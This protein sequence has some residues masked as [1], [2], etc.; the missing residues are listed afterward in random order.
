MYVAIARGTADVVT[1]TI[2]RLTPTGIR[3]HSGRE[4]AADLIVTATGLRLRPVGGLQL[5]VDDEPVDL[6]Q[7]VAYRGI[8]PSGVPNFALATGYVNAS[9]TLRI[10]LIS[11]Y[12]CRLLAYLDRHGFTQ[13]W[14]LAPPPGT[15]TRPLIDISAGYIQRASHTLPRQSDLDPWRIHQSYLAER[16]LLGRRARLAEGMEFRRSPAGQPGRPRG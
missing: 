12:V 10:D 6:T 5:V 4:I 16:R 11:R 2:E 9:W 14:P 3:L 1:D 7:T 8:M 15:T 13:A